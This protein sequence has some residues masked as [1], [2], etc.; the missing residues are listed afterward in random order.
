MR[1]CPGVKTSSRDGGEER[2]K[3]KSTERQILPPSAQISM[4]FAHF[5]SSMPLNSLL[6][7]W[8]PPE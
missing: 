7:S 4:D 3:R 6:L 2:G 5:W 1:V 8:L